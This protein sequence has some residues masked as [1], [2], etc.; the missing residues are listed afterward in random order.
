[1]SK[2]RWELVDDALVEVIIS[3]HGMCYMRTTEEGFETSGGWSDGGAAAVILAEEFA[4]RGLVLAWLEARASRDERV[5]V[6]LEAHRSGAR[7]VR[8]PLR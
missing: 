5:R 6:T 7:V 8:L 2:E 4:R 1:M 3:A